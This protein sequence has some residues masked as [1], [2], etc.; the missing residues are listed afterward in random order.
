[1]KAKKNDILIVVDMQNDFI[2]GVLGTKEAVDILPRVR[3]KI[4]RWKGK[5]IF[6]RDTHQKET[7]LKNSI[8]GT[9]IPLHCVKG[10]S[11]WEIEESLTGLVKDGETYLDKYDRFADPMI[12]MKCTGIDR[13]EIVGVCTDICVLA[14]ALSFRCAHPD[15][16]I[17]VD[18]SC[19]AGTNPGKHRQALEVMKSCCINVLNDERMRGGRN[20]IRAAENV[21][22]N[23][24][25]N[26]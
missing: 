24:T 9:R 3:E 5:V 25:E 26:I 12:A 13:I 11:G 20:D 17:Y 22:E 7:Y 2:T 1:M 18:A 19:C 14:T 23:K 16:G 15:I 10:S 8:E 21:S 6:T 4:K